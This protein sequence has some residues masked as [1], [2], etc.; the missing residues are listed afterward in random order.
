MPLFREPSQIEMMSAGNPFD[1]AA[2]LKRREQ[3]VAS[4]VATL[5]AQTAD[6][7]GEVAKLRQQEAALTARGN[8]PAGLYEQDVFLSNLPNP[9]AAGYTGR[10]YVSTE[11]ALGKTRSALSEAESRSKAGRE[12]AYRANRKKFLTEV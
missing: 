2:E 1:A 6:N 11:Q 8:R 10:G 7:T 5:R 9:R 12:A 3:Q 4:E